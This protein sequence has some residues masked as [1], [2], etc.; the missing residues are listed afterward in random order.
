MTR[1]EISYAIAAEVVFLGFGAVLS[2]IAH[3]PEP[4]AGFAIVA[5]G[6]PLLAGS[7]YVVARV[8]ERLIGGGR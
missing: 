6:A 1:R 2:A 4:F 5:L 7:I 3:R 8:V